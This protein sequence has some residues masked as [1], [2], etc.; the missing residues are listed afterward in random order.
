MSVKI[1][2]LYVIEVLDRVDVDEAGSGEIIVVVGLFEVMIGEMLV[3]FEDPWS[4]LV[5]IVDE[6]SISVT[7][8]INHLLL[9][10]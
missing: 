4:L 8:G 9:V 10:G 3:D 6:L 5:I 2:E 1:V 7:I